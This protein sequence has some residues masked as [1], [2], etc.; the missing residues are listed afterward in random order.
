MRKKDVVLMATVTSFESLTHPSK[1]EL[2]QFAELFAPLF[3]AS[4]DKAR[5]EAVAALSQSTT[6][7]PAVAFFIGCQPIAIAAPFLTASSCLSD[8]ALITIARSQGADHAK[9]IVRRSNL[10]PTVIDALVGFRYG[11]PA[12]ETAPVAEHG[13]EAPA[14]GA[15]S[16]TGSTAYRT[17]DE[18][19]R[20]EDLRRRVK[21]LAAHV[22]GHGIGGADGAPADRL[23]LRSLSPIQQALMVRFARDRE[24][25]LLASVLRDVLSTSRWLAERILLDLSGLRLA[26]VLKS[27]DLEW[28]DASFVLTRLY[29]HLAEDESGMA[30]AERLWQSLDPEDCADLVESWRRA[31]RDMHKD[32][33]AENQGG[34]PAMASVERPVRTSATVRRHV[35]NGRMR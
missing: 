22:S 9:A 14:P 31:D 4:S 23:G 21:L 33:A 20:D 8:E 35:A 28:A 2:K 29:S 5:R 24:G 15:A 32:R 34:A 12:R 1:S 6:V 7:P 19:A 25:D 16:A 17:S 3:S 10:S 18:L 13:S 11:K 27:L 30:R 26:T